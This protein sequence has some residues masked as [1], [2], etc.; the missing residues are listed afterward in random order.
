M[1]H[2]LATAGTAGPRPAPADRTSVAPGGRPGPATVAGSRAPARSPRAG[3]S[4]SGRVTGCRGRPLAT[5]VLRGKARRWLPGSELRGEV[6]EDGGGRPGARQPEAG[7]GPQV[8]PV[9]VPGL[10]GGRPQLP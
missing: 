3:T 2:L 4:L 6:G 5:T 10:R 8:Q 9:G 1:G 7:A